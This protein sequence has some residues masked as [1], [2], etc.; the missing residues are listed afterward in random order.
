[1]LRDY[2]KGRR[3]DVPRGQVAVLYPGSQEMLLMNTEIR[4]LLVSGSDPW[5]DSELIA[6]SLQ[7]M[8]EILQARFEVESS[9]LRSG[10]RVGVFIVIP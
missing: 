6:V 5:H 3:L 8:S 7:S 1:M 10:R 4:P 9:P 2:L